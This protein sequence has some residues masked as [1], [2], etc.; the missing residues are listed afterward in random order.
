MR[1]CSTRIRM[2]IVEEDGITAQ[3]SRT[4]DGRR[5][6]TMLGAWA[7]E[8]TLC[9]LAAAWH[10]VPLQKHPKHQPPPRITSIATYG[11]KA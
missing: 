4:D 10:L 7:V 8:V 1:L 2:T 3:T 6:T 5:L 9:C 11:S